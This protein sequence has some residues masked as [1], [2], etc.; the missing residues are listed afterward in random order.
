MELLTLDRTCSMAELGSV[1]LSEIRSETYFKR[2][3]DRLVRE[4]NTDQ[5]KT[6]GIFAVVYNTSF[7]D[8]TILSNIKKAGF[9]LAGRYKGFSGNT[10][11]TFLKYY[12]QPKVKK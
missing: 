10:V 11:S 1:S 3:V 7:K 9:K 6:S 2:N 8:K 4:A 5:S 12:R